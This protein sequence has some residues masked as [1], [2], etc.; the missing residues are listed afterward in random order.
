MNRVS[1]TRQKKHFLTTEMKNELGKFESYDPWPGRSNIWMPLNAEN[2][3]KRIFDPLSR[4]LHN[5]VQMEL[6]GRQK[7]ENELTQF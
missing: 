1:A 5:S 2:E 4:G 3:L 7:T 6:S